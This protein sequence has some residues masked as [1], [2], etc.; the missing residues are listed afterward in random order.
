MAGLLGGL[1]AHNAL[2][3]VEDAGL[4]LRLQAAMREYAKTLGTLEPWQAALF[5]EE[6]VPQA[7]RFVRDYRPAG[8]KVAIDVD[9]ESLKNYLKFYAPKTLKREGAELFVALRPEPGCVKCGESFGEIRKLVKERVERRGLVPVF[10]L[11]EG[12][13]DPAAAPKPPAGKKTPPAS[14]SGTRPELR[15]DAKLTGKTL[16]ERV[17]ALAGQTKAAGTL[18]VEWRKAPMDDVD[19]AHADEVRFQVRMGLQFRDILKQEGSLEIFENGSFD[20][21][22]SQILTDFL[23]ELGSK[24]DKALLQAGAESDR[25]GYWLE[26]SGIRDF[27]QFNELKTRL[28][29][30]VATKE[31]LS[32]EER[33][34]SRGKA[35]FEVYSAS[36]RTL[37]EV[38]LLFSEFQSGTT[39]MEW[40]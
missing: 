31:G 34:L 26:L 2:A 18:L 36:P 3:V 33:K 39:K 25:E 16:D 12:L 7:S 38:K 9:L 22:V 5:S 20:R 17:Q 23:T 10:A 14:N 1:L 21:T 27:A 13:E 32:F 11:P 8:P 30:F 37:D 6:V 28:S 29:S 24:A 19:A 35:V 15:F 40:R 4:N